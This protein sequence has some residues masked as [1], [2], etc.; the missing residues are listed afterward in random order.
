MAKSR[1]IVYF[2]PPEKIVNGGVMSVFSQ[3][4]EARRFY[5]IHGSEVVLSVYP[6]RETYGKNDLF[7]NNETVYSFDQ[8]VRKWPKLESLMLHI[9]ECGV[10]ASEKVLRSDYFDYVTSVGSL[11]INVMTQNI[12]LMPPQMDFARL[13]RL[14]PNITQTTAH[15]KYTTQELSDNYQTPVHHLSVYV[16]HSQYRHPAYKQKH[17]L[18]LYSPDDNQYKETVLKALKGLK[19]YELKEVRG[20][21]F[22]DYKKLT[23]DAKFCITFGEGFDGYFVESFLSGGIGLAV[24]NELF[25]PNA[26]FS[27]LPSVFRDYPAMVKNIAKVIKGLDNIEAFEACSTQGAAKIEELYKFDIYI[28]KM[29]AFYRSHYDLKPTNAPLIHSLF[30]LLDSK[31]AE[32]G[33]MAESEK[34]L[35]LHLQR[36][37]TELAK[38][39][40]L[41]NDV[42]N[43]KSWKLTRPLRGINKQRKKLF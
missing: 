29:E 42:I 2:V 3:C 24:Y 41:L 33:R 40:S 18:I 32:I 7:P 9:P 13:F 22:E 16:D 20:L 17:N 15:S 4:K 26:G 21:R 30:E 1:L 43:S 34:S 37:Q 12:K 5:D 25:F 11:H 8:I 28:K 39:E 38:K 23:A 10:I 19:S 6:G 31:D 36:T 27:E 35:T 14:T